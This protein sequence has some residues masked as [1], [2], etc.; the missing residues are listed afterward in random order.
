[1][2]GRKQTVIT[3]TGF[4]GKIEKPLRPL[5]PKSTLDQVFG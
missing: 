2:I 4:P 1:M 3:L 5:D